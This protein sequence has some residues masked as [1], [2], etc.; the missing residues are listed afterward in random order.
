MPPTISSILTARRQVPRDRPAGQRE[1]SQRRHPNLDGRASAARRRRRGHLE[2][3]SPQPHAGDGL[4]HSRVRT[5]LPAACCW[6]PPCLLLPLPLAAAAAC[7]RCRLL[8]HLLADTSALHHKVPSPLTPHPTPSHS[9]RFDHLS[10]FSARST[11]AP[12]STKTTR[13]SHTTWRSASLRPVS[14]HRCVSVCVHR[15]RGGEWA[16]SHRLRCDVHCPCTRPR[17]LSCRRHHHCCPP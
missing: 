10:T 14:S 1:R 17:Y 6:P 5:S 11:S 13:S 9:P 8:Q 4:V 7:C 2:D 16:W 15:Q 12:S 3:G